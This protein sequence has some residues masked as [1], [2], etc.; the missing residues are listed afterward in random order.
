MSENNHI[1]LSSLPGDDS[2]G[3]CSEE[4][5]PLMSDNPTQSVS[6][7]QSQVSTGGNNNAEYRQQNDVLSLS[8]Q[9]ES[10][11]ETGFSN[12][13]GPSIDNQPGRRESLVVDAPI[14]PMKG[15]PDRCIEAESRTFRVDIDWKSHHY[16]SLWKFSSVVMLR[17]VQ[18]GL[19]IAYICL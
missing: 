8:Q 5:L 9:A 1:P 2:S 19:I 12:N 15:T 13:T 18:L 4:D 6:E 11:D 3:H 17:L 10:I 7:E 16:R 14:D